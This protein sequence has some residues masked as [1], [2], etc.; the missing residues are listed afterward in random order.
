MHI[1]TRPDAAPVAAQLYHLA[2]IYQDFLKQEIKK[3]L[4]A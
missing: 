4:D 3:L 1:G 2:L